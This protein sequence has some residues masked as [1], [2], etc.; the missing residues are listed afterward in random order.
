MSS[1]GAHF[2]V[3]RVSVWVSSDANCADSQLTGNEILELTQ[4]AVHDYWNT[5]SSSR[6]R[7]VVAGFW[8]QN[9]S[10]F[11]TGELCTPGID[12]D[13]TTIP[14]VSH[15]VISCNSNVAN[16]SSTTYAKTSIYI[17]KNE[18][19]GANILINNTAGA[20]FGSLTKRQKLWVIAHELGHAAG[21][22]H[23]KSSKNLMFYTLTP[24][25]VALGNEDY[26]GMSY[27]YPQEHDGCGL[28]GGTVEPKEPPNSWWSSFFF[29]AFLIIALI[30][31][32]KVIFKRFK[33][34][35]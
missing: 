9:V 7:F 6:L 11:S 3:D 21:L 25:R 20:I 17:E 29:G 27:L 10:R 13:N 26:W 34:I 15:V 2:K 12:C 4:S 31:L 8:N 35:F 19:T 18:I 33:F 23:S 30:F 14:L 1:N 16:F 28:I 24:D 22:G 32:Q 5:I